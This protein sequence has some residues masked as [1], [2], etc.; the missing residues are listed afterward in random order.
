MSGKQ[1][2][3]SVFHEIP[4]R[5]SCLIYAVYTRDLPEHIK[6]KIPQVYHSASSLINHDMQYL[7]KLLD[8]NIILKAT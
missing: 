3:P 2:L 5:T 1:A 6:M 7:L 4:S 8:I